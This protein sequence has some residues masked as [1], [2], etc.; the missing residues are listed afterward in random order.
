MGSQ[1]QQELLD[2]IAGELQLVQDRVFDELVAVGMAGPV[3]TDLEQVYAEWVDAT[4]AMVR[5]CNGESN[6]L[7]GA[8]ISEGII[9]DF[10]AVVRMQAEA[11]LPARDRPG[12]AFSARFRC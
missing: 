5:A 9:D 8:A 3:V 2:G 6:R 1:T 7:D 10:I 12:L 4:Q 11:E